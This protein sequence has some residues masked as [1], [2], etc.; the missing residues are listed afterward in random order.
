MINII[1]EEYMIIRGKRINDQLEQLNEQ[2]TYNQLKTN[3]DN[4]IPV[5]TKRQNAVDPVQVVEL[6]TLPFLG[7]KNLNIESTVTNS[8]S[9]SPGAPA[10]YKPKLIFNQVAFEDESTNE[11]ITFTAKDNN[12]YNMQPIDLGVSTVRVRCGC[13]DF[14]WR[15]AAFNAKDKS[16]IGTAPAPYQRKSNR[17]PVNPQQVP[18]VCKHL[19]KTI[20]ALKQSGMVR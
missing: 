18:G 19:I 6:M 11:N 2:S 16:L 14:L 8:D 17:G 15:F 20:E 4:F 3:V 10:N 1:M 5:S 12:E 9:K 7:T 13:P